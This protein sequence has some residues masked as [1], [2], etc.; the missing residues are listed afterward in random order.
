MKRPRPFQ[1]P[2]DRQQ[3][4][5]EMVNELLGVIRGQFYGDVPA[6]KWFQDQHLIKQWFVLWP[7]RWLDER[8]VTLPPGRYKEILLGILDTIK[9]HGNTAGIDY[10]PRY[11]AKCVQSHFAVHGEEYYEEGKS[12]R[13]AL[14]RALAT[15]QRAQS[16][17]PDPVRVLA[18]ASRAL[19]TAKRAKKASKAAVQSLLF[20]L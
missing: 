13:A 15:A 11:L 5:G 8:G 10:W 16:T 3:T 7:A 4:P 18:E 17:T 9:G 12:V 20:D 19:A 2:R 1:E 6:K 14:D